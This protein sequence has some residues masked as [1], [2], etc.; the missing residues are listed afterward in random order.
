MQH[1]KSDRKNF[2]DEYITF[3][4]SSEALIFIYKKYGAE[5]LLGKKLS[6]YLADYVPD[7]STKERLLIK[8]FYERGISDLFRKALNGSD[9]DKLEAVK[10]SKNNTQG[11]IY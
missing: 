10:K 6:A 5:I 9:D 3:D 7:I 8:S 1:D 4:T 2:S 11:S